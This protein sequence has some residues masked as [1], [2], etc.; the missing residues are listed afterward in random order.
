MTQYQYTGWPDFGVPASP[1]PL[2][3]LLAFVRGHQES[4]L[5]TVVVHCSAGVGRTGKHEL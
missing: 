1:E 5:A 3:A 4:E 2:L